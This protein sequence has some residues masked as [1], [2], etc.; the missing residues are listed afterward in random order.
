M[1]AACLAFLV[2]LLAADG[3]AAETLSARSPAVTARLHL[4]AGF[5]PRGTTVAIRG[6]AR[7]RRRGVAVVAL[8]CADARCV[9]FAR[10]GRSLRRL[11]RGRRRRSIRLRVDPSPFVRVELRARRRVLAHATLRRPAPATPAPQPPAAPPASP[12][13]SFSVTPPLNPAYDPSIPDYTVACERARTVRVS[14]DGGERT[15]ALAAGQAF[16]FSVG[17]RSH[18]ARCLP[19]IWTGW[20]VRRT[21]T[22]QS[23]WIVFNTRAGAVGYTVIAD[24]LGVPVWWRAGVAPLQDG[25][26][27]PDGSVAVGRVTEGSYGRHPYEHVALDGTPL[28]EFDTVG[29]SADPHELQILPNGNALMLRYVRRD[30][31]DLSSLGGPPDATV[32]DGEI[33]EV[34]PQHQLVWSWRSSDHLASD[35]TTFPLTQVRALIDGREAYDLVHLNSLQQDGDGVL[36]SARNLDAV[37]RI[38]RADGSVDWKLGGTPRA[39]SLDFLAGPFGPAGL[40]GQHQARRLPD[41]TITLHDNGTRTGRP[42]RALRFALDPL[43]RTATVIERVT[44]PRVATSICCGGA[45][46]LAGGHWLVSWGFA[47]IITELTASGRPVLTLTLDSGFSY[48]AQSVPATLLSRAALRA[49]MDAMVSRRRASGP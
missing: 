25:R 27:L 38:R 41:G 2:C 35:E 13:A 16:S 12:R 7:V 37:Y 45:T 9:R 11:S 8:R 48:R 43:A 3:A 22:P 49:G 17:G 40:G 39:E 18:S 23:E 30:D 1:R 14:D 15:L 42:P 34:T 28:G 31:V 5:A 29:T 33:Q 24:G 21:G 6:T 4:T 32:I 36:L 46:R 19:R 44:D 10:R 20:A 26:V 47:P